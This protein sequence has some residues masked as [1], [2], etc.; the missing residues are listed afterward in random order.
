LEKVNS[1]LKNQRDQDKVALEEAERVLS[2]VQATEKKYVKVAKE[3]AK[4]RKDLASLDDD[5]FWN[6]LD[7][8]QEQYKQSVS[9][10]QEVRRD[11]KYINNRP[12]L[13]QEIDKI[14]G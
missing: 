11:G 14:L 9:I 13:A 8:L 6:D 4:L 7:V 5:N 1:D 3:N 12:A 10:L 2:L